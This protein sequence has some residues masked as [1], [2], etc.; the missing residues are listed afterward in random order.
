M[1]DTRNDY[2]RPPTDRWGLPG[3]QYPTPNV[4][5][6]VI[7]EEVSMTAGAE[8]LIVGT[9]HKRTPAAKLVQCSLQKGDNNSR[10]FRCIYAKPRS[11]Q[12]PY[13]A[14][15]R[16]VD[17]SA[18]HKIYTRS[19]V[20]LRQWT[21]ATR[22]APLTS[23]VWIEV[24]AGGA[25][26]TSSPT[27]SFTGGNG[28][29]AE[30]TAVV[31][32]GAVV[33]LLLTDGG[34]GYTSAPAVG[35][36]GGGGTGATA[37]TEIQPS[38][39]ILTHEEGA[40]VQGELGAL[41]DQVT[42]VYTTLPGP[43]IYKVESGR[44]GSK[45]T[46]T[47]QKVVAGTTP[48]ITGGLTL[49]D[50]VQETSDT[51]AV[52]TTVAQG[53]SNP[54]V[55]GGTSPTGS[56]G[57]PLYTTERVG[58]EGLVIYTD[59][60][61]AIASYQLPPVEQ[62]DGTTGNYLKAGVRHFVLAA[63]SSPGEGKSDNK[64][65]QIDYVRASGAGPRHMAAAR[66]FVEDSASW[67][68]FVRISY[69]RHTT[70]QAAATKRSS[71]AGPAPALDIPSSARLT[72]ETFDPAGE[73]MPGYDRV[74]R[75]YHTLAGGTYGPP[76]RT[77]KTHSRGLLIRTTR[78]LVPPATRP[79]ATGGF[80]LESK[81]TQQSTTLAELEDAEIVKAA[82]VNG[83]DVTA[84]GFPIITTQR[85]DPET[86][87]LI[88]TDRFLA[89]EPYDL[90]ITES[91]NQRD[92][93]TGVVI[94]GSV[95]VTESEWF[96]VNAAGN[97]YAEDNAAGVPYDPPRY[98]IGARKSPADDDSDNVLIEIEYAPAPDSKTNDKETGYTFPGWFLIN[99]STFVPNAYNGRYPPPW[100]IGSGSPNG[101]TCVAPRSKVWTA[102]EYV[103]YT[104]G[105][106]SATLPAVYNLVTRG[107]GSKVFGGL[108]REK[109]AHRRLVWYEYFDDGTSRLV[110]DIEASTPAYYAM[111][112]IICI[113]AKEER[114]RGNIFRQSV[115]MVSELTALTETMP[116]PTNLT[117]A[118][119]V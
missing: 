104:V 100:N 98:V 90:P 115:V 117:V 12:D 49:S 93:D 43:P 36:S 6:L 107:T 105:K 30:A 5:D 24:T 72:K 53:A 46:T 1:A 66:S 110:E 76:V 60:F 58:S 78:T 118:P 19:Y 4:E 116:T 54:S 103:T 95:D 65:V 10:V 69:E 18:G 71:T 13:N 48:G 9:P 74:T 81:V 99:S 109:M 63:R 21:P 50:E 31:Q 22:L 96:Q 32:N 29:G 111:T 35:F 113:S 108:I 3:V 25:N 7:V 119:Y 73:F 47:T 101:Y 27:V 70:P 75:V 28:A 57:F 51:E 112:D 17:E 77:Y 40:P 67:P 83:V 45:V 23:V 102:K 97:G 64:F 11:A 94:P 62:A 82:Q 8:P 86:G 84:T 114:W 26:Y 106:T 20:E 2:G 14:S 37:T 59:H 38:A 92:V 56:G 16:F 85:R 88:S 39:A 34:D 68:V 52:K 87:V 79:S 44:S 61:E 15:L 91:V 41:F 55:G 80:H 89:V 33:A 42:R